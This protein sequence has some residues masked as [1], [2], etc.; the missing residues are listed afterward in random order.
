MFV[1]Q[2]VIM[3]LLALVASL[4]KKTTELMTVF[5]QQFGVCATE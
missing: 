4:N 1:F 3:L 2:N 5:V